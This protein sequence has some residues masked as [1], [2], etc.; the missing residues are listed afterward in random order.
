MAHTAEGLGDSPLLSEVLGNRS[1]P[2]T[3][4]ISKVTGVSPAEAA[5][6]FDGLAGYR[7]EAAEMAKRIAATGRSYY[8]QFPAPLELYALVRLTRPRR[9][10]ESGVSSGVSSTFILMGTNSNHRGTLHSIDYPVLRTVRGGGAPWALPAGMGTGWAVP[11]LLRRRW[12]LRLGRSEDLLPPLLKELGGLDF[13]CHDSPVDH[14]HFQFEMRTISRCL[15][16]GS[17]VV[18]DNTDWESFA[19]AARSLGANAVRRKRSGLGAFRVPED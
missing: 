16:P 3:L 13:Y 14:R 5:S 9:L 18:A 1:R 12:D 17:V 11:R 15:A 8:A 6:A 10:V 19:S 7:A 4:W 2:D